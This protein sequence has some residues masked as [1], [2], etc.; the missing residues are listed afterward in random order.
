MYMI[1]THGT[2]GRVLE[3][4]WASNDG[5]F[6]DYAFLGGLSRLQRTPCRRDRCSIVTRCPGGENI[7]RSTR[8]DHPLCARP[9]N[10]RVA[11]RTAICHHSRCQPLRTVTGIS[12]V[13][14]MAPSSVWT[15]SALH[16]R[17]AALQQ[18]ALRTLYSKQHLLLLP[19]HCLLQSHVRRWEDLQPYPSADEAATAAEIARTISRRMRHLLLLTMPLKW[20]RLRMWSLLATT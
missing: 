3:A 1:F 8:W 6:T 2:K 7:R 12:S 20:R 9:G 14:A 15:R 11:L 19:R 17:I 5:T 4:A 16:R 18:H 13:L 10:F